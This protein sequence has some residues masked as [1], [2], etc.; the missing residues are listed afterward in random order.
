MFWIVIVLYQVYHYRLSNKWLDLRLWIAWMLK[1]LS[2]V[3]I[4]T[5]LLLL[6]KS[7]LFPASV[8]SYSNRCCLH[9]VA[10]LLLS[11]S[12]SE[13]DRLSTSEWSLSADDDVICSCCFCSCCAG[14]WWTLGAFVEATAHAATSAAR[15]LASC[16]SRFCLRHL[17]RRFLNQTCINKD[18]KKSEKKC[19]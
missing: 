17:A 5:P 13:F 10:A 12:S 15:L 14:W 7:V 8:D 19:G 3:S 1:S 4:F 2:V 16:T 9:P 11:S 18:F 6:W